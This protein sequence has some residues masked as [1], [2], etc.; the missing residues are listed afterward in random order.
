MPAKPVVAIRAAENGDFE[1]VQSLM[2]KNLSPYYDGDHHA[3]ATRIFQTH[4]SGGTDKLGFF[5]V[6]QSMF[7]AAVGH[8]RVGLLH[9]V[10]KRQ[11]TCKISP[12][13][14]AR[15]A[16]GSGVG[17]ALLEKAESFARLNDCRQ[18]Y[19]TVSQ[20]N[21]GALNLF[22]RNGFIPA[23]ESVNHYKQG[24]KEVMLYKTLHEN[25]GDDEFDFDHISVL[26]LEEGQ[27]D[28]VRKLL[29][30]EL[31]VDFLGINDGWVDSLFAGYDRRRAR[32]VDQKYKLI[33]T[34]T[35]RNNRVLGVVGATPKKGEPIKLMPFVA[36]DTPSFFA[37]LSDVPALL[38][39]Y[40]KK[41]YVHIVPDTDQTRFLQN[42]GWR[43]DG[44]M[45]DSYQVGCV[46]QQWSKNLERE[47]YMPQMRLKKRYL[48]LIK[49][50]SKTLE[51]RVGYKFVLALKVGEQ[52]AFVSRG[53]RVIKEIVAIRKY[54]SF[55]DM[56]ESEDH[57]KIVP[58]LSREEV[59]KLLRE[60]YP[61]AKEALGVYVIEL[62]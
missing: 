12:L 38:A 44:V 2:V 45:P 40:G 22:L 6:K 47:Q 14:V 7:I 21:T 32:D 43:L 62:A 34:A 37:L 16:R 51:V 53:D 35:D 13:I 29:L 15:D 24:R 28:Q 4:I 52:I 31:P 50:D 20:K 59:E 23:G 25:V 54:S 1:F 8:E 9:L 33:F 48:D 41:V 11:N 10:I 19:C 60:I 58:G 5:S 26:P 36:T 39:D 46:T 3:H 49:A 57:T 30:E 56:F 61:P 27:K 42:S 17:R 18:I 55:E